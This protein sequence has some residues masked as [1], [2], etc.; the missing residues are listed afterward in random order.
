[1]VLARVGFGYVLPKM[2]ALVLVFQHSVSVV[3]PGRQSVLTCLSHL[4]DPCSVRCMVFM[5]PVCMIFLFSITQAKNYEL[6]G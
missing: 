3:S 1:M 4:G 5:V 2:M 6:S